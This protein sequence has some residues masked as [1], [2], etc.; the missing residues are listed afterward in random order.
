MGAGGFAAPTWAGEGQSL[1]LMSV[2]A[3]ATSARMLPHAVPSGRNRNSSQIS[4]SVRNGADARRTADRAW[5]D[6]GRISSFPGAV[7]NRVRPSLASS[8]GQNPNATGRGQNP[9][10]SVRGQRLNAAVRRQSLNA[11]VRGQNPNATV[12]GQNLSA[13]ARGRNPALAEKLP[14]QRAGPLGNRS[15][16][17]DGHKTVHP[18]NLLTRPSVVCHGRAR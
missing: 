18:C 2:G 15:Y 16:D 13:L 7:S 12:R 14:P 4:R 6:A 8:R 5:S 17:A 9:N 1:C 3:A 10:A 11:T